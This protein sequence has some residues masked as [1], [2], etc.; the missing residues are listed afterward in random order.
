MRPRVRS[1]GE[2]STSTSSPGVI[3]MRKRRKRPA[4]LARIVCPFSS[5]TL[6]VELGNVSTTRPTR[7][8]VSSLTTG[9]RGS[10]R[11]FLP[12]PPRLRGGGM[13]TPSKDDDEGRSQDAGRP[14]TDAKGERRLAR[15]CR[16]P[17][18]GRFS[19]AG[20]GSPSSPA[21][22][23][24]S[25]QAVLSSPNSPCK[26]QVFFADVHPNRC[27]LCYNQRAGRF[28]GVASSG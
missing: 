1:Y 6:N 22:G 9:W 23:P 25:G 5:S 7:L 24:E 26:A 15:R 21:Y 14:R 10:R 8:S 12:P 19:C 27:D 13:R 2:S 28:R 20:G 17:L 3:R 18:P 16:E 11:R 4:R